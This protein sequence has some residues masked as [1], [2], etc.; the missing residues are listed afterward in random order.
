M[1]NLDIA[2]AATLRPI[3]DVAAELGLD[4]AGFEPLGRTKGKLTTETLNHLASQPLN[5]KLILVTA[6]TPTPAGEGKT[7]TTIGLSQALR[8]LG[9]R[10]ISATREPALGPIFGVKGGACGGG[11]SQV[12]PMEDINLFFTGDFPAITAAHN[13]LSAMIDAHVA[14]G[15]AL[16]IDVR[17]PV[18]PRTVDMNDRALR[19]I[20]VGMGGKANGFVRADGFV[21]LP[22]SEVMAVLCLSRSLGELRDRLGRIHAAVNLKGAPVTAADLQANG[23][24]SAL[25]RDAI[26]PNVVQTI[27]GGPAL[28]HGG[29]FGNIAHGC[30]S[31]L[32]TESGL[33]LADYTVTEAGFAADLGGEKFLNIVAR[34]L[35]RGPDAIVL[36]VTIRALAHHGGGAPDATTLAAGFANVR[37]HIRHL[38]HYGPPVLVAINQFV[39][40]DP[41]LIDLVLELSQA[42]GATAVAANPWGAGGAGCEALGEAVITAAETPSTFR[43]LYDLDQDPTA[44]LDAIVRVAYGA[45][46]ADLTPEAKRKLKWAAQHGMGQAPICVAK[47]QN[48]LSDDPKRLGAPTGWRLRVRDIVVSAGAG[49]LVAIAGDIMRMPGLGADPA[50]HRIDVTPDGRITGLF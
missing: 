42:E 46:G 13:L 26:R 22:A 11:Y 39:D 27:E 18:W 19:E 1:T 49:F 16:G 33:R 44:R 34:S 36:V 25:L 23:A 10:A 30:N 40:D 48:S 2:Q 37:Q 3:A 7:T 31:I 38:R 12:L 17:V 15:N 43:H 21:I 4:D 20:M 24:M 41:A 45:D 32:A 29:P 28:V 35:G 47:T 6:M 14:N 9:K 5:G 50:A 8:R